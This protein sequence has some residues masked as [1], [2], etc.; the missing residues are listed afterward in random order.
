MKFL[1]G[2]PVVDG[3]VIGEAYLLDTENY[4]VTQRFVHPPTPAAAEREWARFQGATENAKL[5]VASELDENVREKRLT[6]STAKIFHG[7]KEM[8]D[9]PSIAKYVRERVFESYWS[10]EYAVSRK[11]NSIRKQWSAIPILRQRL[12]DLD[13][14]QNRWLQQLLGKKR[15]GLRDLDRDVILIA[16]DLTPAQTAN[17]PLKWVR[18]FA[19]ELGGKTSHTAII[20]QSR[21]IPAVVGVN[22]LTAVLGGG[23]TVIVDGLEGQVIIDPDPG[24]VA[25]Y[26]E[27]QEKYERYLRELEELRLLPAETRDGARVRIFANI[28]Y[29]EEIESAVAAGAEGIGLY[30]TEFLYEHGRP[31][32]DEEEH[33]RAY[34]K[35]VDLLGGKPLVIRTLDLGADKFTPE[36]FA[37]EQNPFLGCR[38]I[39]YCLLERRDVFE[40]QLRAILRVSAMGDVRI[41]LPMISSLE[42]LELA[43]KIIEGVKLGL[44]EQGVPFNEEILVGIM[45]EVP[46]AALMADVLARHADFFSIG[47]NDLVQYT[48]A[49]DR[50]NARVAELYQPT[51][52]AVFRLVLQTIEAAR[53]QG[54]PVSICGELSGEPHF[55]LPLVGLGMR[56]LSMTSS[57]IPRVKRFI[58]SISALEAGRTIDKVLAQETATESLDM[59][60]LRAQEIDPELYGSPAES[61]T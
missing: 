11:L 12:S 56:D 14:V 55:A 54:I 8:F 48:L 5:A 32:P 41:M 57:T 16:R 53:R 47:T 4:A 6:D 42:E 49:V 2:I 26:R 46:S 51:H 60:L 29:P 37:D 38:S 35:A 25:Q 40:Q 31:E 34:S 50:V 1:T 36:G 10:P 19:T 22:G 43:K 27:R 61:L 45:I 17:L 30:R 13:D 33:F 59:L 9:D 20:A 58:R 3:V 24:T 15:E 23:E 44:R 52:P 21:Q 28:E 18:G 39:R 7:H